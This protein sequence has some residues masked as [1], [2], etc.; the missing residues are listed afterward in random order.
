MNSRALGGHLRGH[1]CTR[2]R[3]PST[4]H[5][6]ASRRLHSR[7]REGSIVAIRSQW[8]RSALSRVEVAD[9]IF[10]DISL[11]I[12]ARTGL[13]WVTVNLHVRNNTCQNQVTV[14]AC[15]ADIHNTAYR[16]FVCDKTASSTH[17]VANAVLVRNHGFT[18]LVPA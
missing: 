3:S 11:F 5:G 18:V 17:A 4:G 15:I 7:W 16:N 8:S 2:Q 1:H 6:S 10:V 14:I 9:R 13:L 12:V